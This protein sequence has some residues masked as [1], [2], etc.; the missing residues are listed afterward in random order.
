MLT[1]AEFTRSI[2]RNSFKCGRLTIPPGQGLLQIS[3]L[4]DRFFD[5]PPKIGAQLLQLVKNIGQK[6]R[7]ND[8]ESQ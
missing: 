7:L 3:P 8:L 4:I 2:F 6:V 5:L 1:P